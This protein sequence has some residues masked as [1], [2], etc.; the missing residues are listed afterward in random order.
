MALLDVRALMAQGGDPFAAIMEAVAQLGPVE[1]LELTAPLDPVPLYTVL[2]A[3]GYGHRTEDLGGGDYRVVF[4][5]TQ[6]PAGD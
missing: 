3:R 5:P 1:P 2:E 4:T 6:G